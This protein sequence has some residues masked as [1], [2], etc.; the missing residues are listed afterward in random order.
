MTYARWAGGRGDVAVSGGLV[1]MKVPLEGQD[2][3]DDAAALTGFRRASLLLLL[4]LK[5]LEFV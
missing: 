2:Q 5:N 1:S 4:V 3:L